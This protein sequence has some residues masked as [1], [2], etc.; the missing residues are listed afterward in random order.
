MK[1]APFIYKPYLLNYTPASSISFTNQKN[2][3]EKIEYAPIKRQI[4]VKNSFVQD[5]NELKIQV[6]VLMQYLNFVGEYRTYV[7]W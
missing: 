2:K 1:T 7:D 4:V 6:L 5:E 3:D